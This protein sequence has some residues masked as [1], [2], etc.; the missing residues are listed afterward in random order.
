MGGAAL[1]AEPGGIQ[2][3]PGRVWRPLSI[4]LLVIG[5]VLAPVALN[6]RSAQHPG[7]VRIGHLPGHRSQRHPPITWVPSD[8]TGEMSPKMLPSGSSR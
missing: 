1:T 5:C 3:G 4:V 2:S 8:R 7:C 6:A